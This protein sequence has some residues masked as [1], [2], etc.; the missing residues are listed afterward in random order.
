[1]NRIDRRA[2]F[3]SGAAAALL[4]ATGVSAEPKRGG[5]LR[6]A[7]SSPEVLNQAA[8]TC[9]SEGLTEIAADGT[10]RGEIATH[11]HG[12][13]SASTWQFDLRETRFHDASP[14]T[15]ADLA[16]S[17]SHLGQVHL[18]GS[19]LTL[20]LYQPNPN[21]PFDLA[22][23]RN[24]IRQ[25][26]QSTQNRSGLYKL[27]KL[28]PGRHFIADRLPQHWKDAQAGWF[29]TIELVLFTDDTV[30]AQALREGLVDLADIQTKD[31]FTDPKAFIYLPDPTRPTQVVSKAI[32]LPAKVGTTF[33][34]DNL[35]MSER[36][37]FA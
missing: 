15:E 32:A 21:L 13:A 34:L 20:T 5:R 7:L 3:T 33:P 35:R 31:P 36:W 24:L 10:L 28:T 11:W 2:L 16:A 12:D 30:R 8:E 18:D 6:V 14:L 9:L 27:R 17:L 19:R 29:D 4:A 26:G 25:A 22:K 1:M 37:W 23:P